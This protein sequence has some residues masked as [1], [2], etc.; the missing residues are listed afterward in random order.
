MVP[1]CLL[2]RLTCFPAAWVGRGQGGGHTCV[3]VSSLMPSALQ[4][5]A[6]RRKMAKGIRAKPVVSVFL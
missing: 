2:A 3:L 6:V 5:M 4:C 1:A